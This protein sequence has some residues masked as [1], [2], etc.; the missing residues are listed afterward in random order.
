MS[1]GKF[2]EQLGYLFYAVS[3][4]R[5]SFE[6]TEE[7]PDY[8]TQVVPHFLLLAILECLILLGTKKPNI[9]LN[10]SI[11]SISQGVLQQ[12]LSKVFLRSMQISA[13]TYIYYNWRLVTLPWDSLWTWWLCFLGVDLGYY[14]LH[15]A[16]HEINILWAAHQVHHSSEDYNLSTALRQSALQ[17]YCVWMFYLPMALA[18]PP[19]AFLVHNQFNLLYQFW[20][21]TEIIRSLG[22]LEYILNTASHHRVHH[23]RN[24]Y[25][26]DKNY[27][28]T[29]IIWDRIFG[30]FQAEGEQVVYGLT[31]PINSFE[32]F[33]IQLCHYMHISR[34]FWEMKGLGNKLSVI[35]K[36]PGWSPGTPWHG[37]LEDIPDVKAPIEKYDPPLPMWCK[38]YALLHTIIVVLGYVEIA[39]NSKTI[40][41][42]ILW[43]S[44]IYEAFSLSIIG[45]LL[46]GRLYAPS[47]EMVRCLLYFTLDY[48]FLPFTKLSAISSVARWWIVQC[49]R[50][51]YVSSF[52]F[53]MQYCFRSVTA[54]MHSNKI[55]KK[56]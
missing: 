33:Y 16:S 34:T 12:T 17:N 19:S 42:L 54:K 29:L 22:P 39:E 10:D 15:R 20:I 6:T 2:A 35:F 9:R 14:W 28:G 53:W 36:G 32:P 21:H 7:V 13:Y 1:T 50:T 30:T 8:V 24:R 11:G 47:I 49:L 41:Q 40:P 23:G 52:L 3:P 5:T 26:I 25:C 43:G 46:E 44:V 18:I 56:D 27:G 38:V 45:M 48:F 31:H 51:I 55:L 37:Y 4:N